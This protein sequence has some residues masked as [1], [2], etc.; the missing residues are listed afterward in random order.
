LLKDKDSKAN[1]AA[2]R[3]RRGRHFVAKK[4]P[5]KNAV[6]Q[7]F[8]NRLHFDKMTGLFRNVS[9]TRLLGMS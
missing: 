5:C 7:A 8:L 4:P 1:G 3:G 6:D 2:W 9:R